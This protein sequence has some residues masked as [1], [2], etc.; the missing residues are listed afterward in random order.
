MPQN[1]VIAFAR[2]ISRA[3]RRMRS[4]SMPQTFD[5]TSGG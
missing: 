3:M 5:A 1:T 4:A 2:P